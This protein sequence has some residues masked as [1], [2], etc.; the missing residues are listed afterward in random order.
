MYYESR[1]YK[2][3]PVASFL[4]A[5]EAIKER[6]AY[7]FHAITFNLSPDKE[8]I[9]VDDSHC[10][11]SGFGEVA[12]ILKEDGV[13]KQIESITAGWIKSIEVLA[14]YFSK[15]VTNPCSM[16]IA[17]LNIGQAQ[18]NATANFTC[19]CCGDWFKGVVEEQLKFDQDNGYGICNGCAKYYS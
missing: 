8:V 2:P 19:G 14:D 12:V 1:I 4:E 7:T 18:P 16:G 3:F 15:A 13:F 9:F 11:D 6:K 17:K 10:D 5:A